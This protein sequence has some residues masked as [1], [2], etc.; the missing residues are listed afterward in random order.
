[1][2]PV[3]TSFHKH[4]LWPAVLSVS[5]GGFI[6]D[7]L[8]W[9]QTAGLHWDLR[10][11]ADEQALLQ[12]HPIPITIG[13]SALLSNLQHKIRMAR[14]KLLQWADEDRCPGFF[15]P[16]SPNVTVLSF[17]CWTIQLHT[18]WYQSS[19]RSCYPT[20]HTICRDGGSGPAGWG[21]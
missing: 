18:A 7:N 13:Q 16:N 6:S 11:W 15:P 8:L 10:I 3:W 9:V 21:P 19:V 2:F 17:S 12:R 5:C 20:G 4:Y 1:M 14:K